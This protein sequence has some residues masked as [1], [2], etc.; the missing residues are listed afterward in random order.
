[1]VKL[2]TSFFFGRRVGTGV[3]LFSCGL[4]Y[5]YVTDILYLKG[6]SGL[7]DHP[8]QKE[9]RELAIDMG[10]K[11]ANNLRV[12]LQ[13]NSIFSASSIGHPLLPRGAVVELPMASVAPGVNT[14]NLVLMGLAVPRSHE[15][16]DYML[17]TKDQVMFQAGHE[18]QH[19]LKMDTLLTGPTRALSLPLSFGLFGFL[20]SKVKP[21]L[22]RKMVVGAQ[23]LL[24]WVVF[25]TILER[26]KERRADTL[27]GL[28]SKELAN[29]GV[30]H[31]ERLLS[32]N[33]TTRC[34]IKNESFPDETNSQ[35]ITKRTGFNE[36]GEY[37]LDLL[38]PPMVSRLEAMRELASRS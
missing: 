17:F 36:E 9:I 18:L 10:M 21:T 1:M 34:R 19:I 35:V 37:T 15:P 32:L 24:L 27:A 38:H 14:N 6:R 23:S 26:W 28:H 33:K 7:V 3:G 5:C 29:G 31:F 2:G 11:H 12:V 25:N 22:P 20:L 30:H 16:T 8:L 4:L 13:P